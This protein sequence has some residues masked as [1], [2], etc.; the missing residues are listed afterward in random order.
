VWKTF[1]AVL[2]GLVLTIASVAYMITQRRPAGPAAGKPAEAARPRSAY[3]SRTDELLR[4]N[5]GMASEPTLAAKYDEINVRFFDGR[6]PE[7]RIRWEPRLADVGPLIA[8]GFRL[9]GLTNGRLILLDPAIEDDEQGFRRTLCHEMVHVAVRDRDKGHGPEF[10]RELL[11]L[12][13]EHAFSGI[14]ATEAQKEETQHEIETTAHDLERDMTDLIHQRVA[15]NA[16]TASPDKNVEDLNRRIAEYN[17][18]AQRHNNAVREL[19]ERIGQYNLMISYPDGLDR[20]RMQRRAG[21]P[22]ER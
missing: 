10:Q 6:L 8:E 18:H 7:V 2:P 17:L 11:R 9:D 1:R 5:A 22:A 19:N 13:Q 15:L 3:D 4:L 12:S 21:V 20:E 14:V 16:D